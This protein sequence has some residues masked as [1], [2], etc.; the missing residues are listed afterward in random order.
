[1]PHASHRLSLFLVPK[2]PDAVL[3][4]AVGDSVNGLLRKEGVLAMDDR[5]GANAHAMVVGG[6]SRFRIDWPPDPVV[7]GNRLGG[8]RAECPQCGVSVV[9]AMVAGLRSWRKGEGRGFNCPNCQ[10]RTSLEAVNYAPPAAPGKWALVF[11][12]TESSEV[13]PDLLQKLES[14]CGSELLAIWIRG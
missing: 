8:Y 11:S 7:Y 10:E 4:R 5:A 2:N 13:Q 1:M 9:T 14:L 6:F 3:S 12:R